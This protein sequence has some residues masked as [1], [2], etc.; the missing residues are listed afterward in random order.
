[1]SSLWWFSSSINGVNSNSR[2]N[3][4]DVPIKNLI[5]KVSKISEPSRFWTF[6]LHYVMADRMRR[7]IHSSIASDIQSAAGRRSMD[8]SNVR[9]LSSLHLWTAPPITLRKIYRQ[10]AE[11]QVQSEWK[12]RQEHWYTKMSIKTAK[13]TDRVVTEAPISTRMYSLVD[14]RW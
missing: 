4:S 11:L 9:P 2:P 7:P 10:F 6:V 12:A 1:M 5:T 8:P 3:F 14:G 13:S